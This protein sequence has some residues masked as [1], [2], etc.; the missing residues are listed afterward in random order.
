MIKYKKLTITIPSEIYKGL[1][2]VAGK[3]NISRFLANLARPHVIDSEQQ[4]K[5]GYQEMTADTE[6]ETQ[7]IE[8]SENLIDDS[9]DE[10]R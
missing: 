7:A 9:H 8:W 2:K 1:Y 6:R 4:L 3:R 5:K 10:T